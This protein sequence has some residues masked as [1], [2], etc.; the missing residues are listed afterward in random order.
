MLKIENACIEFGDEVLFKG[1]NLEVKKG[2]IVCISGE[3]GKGKTSLLK[4]IMG[5]VPLKNGT[6]TVDGTLLSLKTVDLVRKKIC[7]MPQELALP[8]EWVSEMVTLPFELRANRHICFA[9]ECLM[10]YFDKLGLAPELY[11]KRVN[12]ISGGQR[13]RI[14]L[15]VTA[16]LGRPVLLVDE[17]TSALDPASSEKV[18]DFFHSLAQAGTTILCVSHDEQFVESCGRK[19]VI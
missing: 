17:P 15:A 8:S 11:D 9:K 2:E 7:W 6:I 14:M 4:A 1:L 10:F 19:L 13:Q 16:M 5:F 12:E 18:H 3:S